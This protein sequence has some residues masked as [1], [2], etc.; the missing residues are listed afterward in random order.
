MNLSAQ[1]KRRPLLLQFFFGFLV[2]ITTFGIAIPMLYGEEIKSACISYLRKQFHAEIFI[3]DSHIHFFSSFPK[4]SVTLHEVHIR[5]KNA[6]F[7]FI[8]AQQSGNKLML[9][10][11]WIKSMFIYSNHCIEQNHYK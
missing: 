6:D 11:Q 8:K 1:P 5:E 7:N 2:L 3:K 4:L 10:N 9:L